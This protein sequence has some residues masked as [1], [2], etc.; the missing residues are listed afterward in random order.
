MHHTWIVPVAA[1]LAVDP[2]GRVIIGWETA[3][4]LSQ[5]S[6]LF[7]ADESAQVI[8]TA[9]WSDR[10]RVRMGAGPMT[11]CLQLYRIPGAAIRLH[12]AGAFNT[13]GEMEA[14]AEFLRSEMKGKTEDTHTLHLVVRWFHAPRAYL[15]LRAR[16]EPWQRE[17]VRIQ[18]RLVHSGDWRSIIREPFAFARNLPRM[19][20]FHFLASCDTCR[21]R[22]CMENRLELERGERTII[23]EYR[24]CHRCG[25]TQ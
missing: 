2:K 24:N 8:V 14:V 5:T 16:L 7:R 17:V 6:E 12:E 11:E 21:G 9:G 25:R 1:D 19:L 4:V 18:V 10:F 15:L 13:N 3:A 20:G 23:S 22:G